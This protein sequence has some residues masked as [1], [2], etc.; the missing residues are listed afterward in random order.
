MFF[1]YG[2]YIKAKF[3]MALYIQFGYLISMPIFYLIFFISGLI[4]ITYDFIKNILSLDEGPDKK[5]WISIN[6]KKDFFSIF[7]FITFHIFSYSIK[8]H[9]LYGMAT[10]IFCLPNSNLYFSSRN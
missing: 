8:F 1:I 2:N 9:S 10:F 4:K 7:L 3:T 6:Q 5:I